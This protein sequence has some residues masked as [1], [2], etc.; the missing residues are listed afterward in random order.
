M[1]S[2]VH[3]FLGKGRQYYFDYSFT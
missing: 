1:V 2:F 3:S